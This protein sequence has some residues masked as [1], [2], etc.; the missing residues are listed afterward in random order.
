MTTCEFHQ[1]PSIESP[2]IRSL[3]AGEK[4]NI[5]DNLADWYKVSLLNL[6][7]GWMKKDCLNL[8]QVGK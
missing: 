4:V 2:L 1:A 8:I 7:Q 5:L 3:A 6:D